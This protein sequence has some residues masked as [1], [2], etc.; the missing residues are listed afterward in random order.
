MIIVTGAAGFIGSCLIS[1]L[2]KK[3]IS[4]I[5]AV[6]VLRENDKWKDIPV[7]AAIHSPVVWTSDGKQY[8]RN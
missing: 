8:Y 2:N 7:F 6:D 3:G 4:D 1:Y 5:I